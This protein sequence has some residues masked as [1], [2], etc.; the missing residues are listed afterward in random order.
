MTRDA[1]F[2]VSDEADDLLEA[3]QH[4][5]RRRRFGDVVRLEVSS[6]MSA[7]DD[8]AATEGLSIGADQVYPVRGMLDWSSW[9]RS[10]GSTDPS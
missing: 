7:G 3:L 6:S 9:R 8:G 4:E 2:E 1:D 5:L 10:R